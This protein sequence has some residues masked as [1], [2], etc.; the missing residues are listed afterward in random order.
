[1]REAMSKG[2][3]RSSA[4]GGTIK[5]YGITV[6]VP[7]TFSA[8][9]ALFVVPIDFARESLERYFDNK[10]IE[11]L[12]AHANAVR[13]ANSNATAIPDPSIR[14]IELLEQ[15][16][17]QASTF[18]DDSPELAAAWRAVLEK[19]QLNDNNAENILL[20]RYKITKVGQ[21]FIESFNKYL[22]TT[23]IGWY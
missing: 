12:A 19:I 1:M 18:G 4:T 21:Q 3:R 22:E 6:P 9:D 14:Q 2:R 10:R 5:A 15:W 7:R 8:I 13:A 17:P 11:N 16:A 23:K 20:S